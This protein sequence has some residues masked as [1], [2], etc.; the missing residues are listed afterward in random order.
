VSGISGWVS[1]GMRP[2]P[3]YVAAMSATL[4][5][6]G[7]DGEGL[8]SSDQ[9]VFGHRRLLT[10]SEDEPQPMV[11]ETSNG[12]VV[13]SCDGRVL[14]CPELRRELEALG[15]P[16]PLR[17]DVAVVL[18]GY[19]RWG[20]AVSGKLRGT[21]AFA[22]WDG[23]ARRLLLTRDHLGAKPLCYYPTPDGVLFGSEPKAI[24]AHPL[25]KAAVDIRGLQGWFSNV[26]TPGDLVW[27]GMRE[28]SPG[29]IVTVDAAGIREQ[30]WRL[31]SRPHTDDPD[32]TVKRIRA[33]LEASMREQ[34]A[35]APAAVMLSGGVDSSVVTALAAHDYAARGAMLASYEIGFEGTDVPD[36]PFA[37]EV[38]TRWGTDHTRVVLGSSLLASPELRERTVWARDQPMGLGDHDVSHLLLFEQIRERFRG[39]LVGVMADEL[40]GGYPVF[41]DPKV[42]Q[43]A[44][45]PRHVHHRGLRRGRLATLN[46]ELRAA[47][48][49]ETY[50]ADTYAQAAPLV[51]PVDGESPADHR[52][53]E[54]THFEIT[55]RVRLL[56]D[57]ID[58]LAGGLQVGMPFG[59]PRLVEYAYNVP[60]SIKT[61][62]GVKGLLKAAAGELLPRSVRERPKSCYPTTPDLGY[63]RAIQRQGRALAAQP[64]HRV[65]DIV[66]RGWLLGATRQPP[67][68]LNEI[69]REGIN[70]ALEL[71][72]WLDL[73]RPT[74]AIT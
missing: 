42:Y 16:F 72:I 17:S 49:L 54:T 8:W 40:F 64:G 14:N 65:F 2:V 31:R 50:W 41:T 24:L 51:E 21:F 35:G 6:R 62:G 55:S 63:L 11:F 26:N 15:A 25:A 7:P 29:A 27:S 28:V 53:R 68:S 34:L 66:D 3:A 48:N 60:R 58:R 22:I 36:S 52:W 69:A 57:F 12:P 4:T 19:L 59:D 23:R 74:I 73:Y 45:W 71:A 5:H 37:W 33:L 13:L 39:V 70:R 9:A 20:E 61:H 30:C 56:L 44:G 10:G 43:E 1:Y 47:L 67:G 32:T 46:P 18:A 38:A